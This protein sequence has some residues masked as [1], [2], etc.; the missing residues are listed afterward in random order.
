MQILL[1]MPLGSPGIKYNASS[2][3]TLDS[4]HSGKL[5]ILLFMPLLML[6]RHILKI[7]WNC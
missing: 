2:M 4:L 5:H 7:N 3:T 1:A 6:L